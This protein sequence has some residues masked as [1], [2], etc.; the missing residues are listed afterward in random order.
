MNLGLVQ[1]KTVY[2]QPPEA[3]LQMQRTG[4]GTWLPLINISITT[5]GF[6]QLYHPY[7]VDRNFPERIQDG[8]RKSFDM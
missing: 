7:V 8:L 2:W 4:P 1:K 6:S 5:P 3:D